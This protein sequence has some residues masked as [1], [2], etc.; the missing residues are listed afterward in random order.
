MQKLGER[1]PYLYLVFRL[2]FRPIFPVQ[3][4]QLT[5]LWWFEGAVRLLNDAE[6]G[7]CLVLTRS[8]HDRLRS[9]P[10]LDHSV[11]ARTI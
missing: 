4:G 8:L 1:T 2:F 7:L 11:P 10:A 5:K 9:A 3:V 6:I